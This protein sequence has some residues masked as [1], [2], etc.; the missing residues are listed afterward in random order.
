MQQHHKKKKNGTLCRNGLRTF[1]VFGK[2]TP[3]E[4]G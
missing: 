4:W 1:F 3:S 2:L